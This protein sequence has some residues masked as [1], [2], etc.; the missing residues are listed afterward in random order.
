MRLALTPLFILWFLLLPALG[1][2][3]ELNCP[4]LPGVSV[5]S[6]DEESIVIICLATQ[7]ALH[8]LG[9]YNLTSRSKIRFDIV[10]EKIVSRGADAY[11]SYDSRSDRI[12]LMSF[13]AIQKDPEHPL[14]FGE[15]FDRVHYAAVV[16]HEVA[17]AVVQHN[18][19][20][21]PLSPAPQEYL[22]YATQLAVI[23]TVRRAAIIK[24]IDIEA[25]ASG[26][27][28]SDIYL[29]IN[30]DKF[31]VKS[32]RHLTGLS[33]PTIFVEMLLGAKWFYVY[34]P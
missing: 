8:F 22:A 15:A 21:K 14:I 18:L 31:A 33:N 20:F 6:D 16:A 23:P 12:Q 27:L 1:A 19:T 29:G 5:T 7:K 3:R 34:V 17:H 11:G 24:A 9:A 4:Y 13:A 2:T 32:Y 28:I 25:W 26:D 10:E 30:P